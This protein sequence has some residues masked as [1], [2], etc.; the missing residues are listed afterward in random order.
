[1]TSEAPQDAVPR[2]SKSPAPP[3]VP[4]PSTGY[5]RRHALHL[6][7]TRTV[8]LLAATLLLAA[9][10]SGDDQSPESSST[11]A[12]AAQTN[13]RAAPAAEDPKDPNDRLEAIATAMA[14]VKSMHF[15][16]TA[17]DDDGKQTLRGDLTADGRAQFS[18]EGATERAEI[19]VI[20]AETFIRANAAFFVEDDDTGTDR[21][22]SA[23]LANRWISIPTGASGLDRELKQLLPST[24]AKCLTLTAGTIRDGGMEELDGQQVDVLKDEGDKPGTTPGQLFSAA[25]GTPLPLRILQTGPTRAGGKKIPEC[26]TDEKDTTTRSDVRL[27][28]FDERVTVTAPEGALKIPTPGSEDEATS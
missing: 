21:A 8:P 6:R 27:S 5:A 20:G 25:E 16:G 24:I 15:E 13:T 12:T 18:I 19:R 11:G 7:C 3:S 28:R 26:G 9:C 23:Q 2:P 22:A 17:T 4:C 14:K 10:G 1:M